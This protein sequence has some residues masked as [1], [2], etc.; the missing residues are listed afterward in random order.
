MYNIVIF[1]LANVAASQLLLEAKGS[2]SGSRI[3]TVQHCSSYLPLLKQHHPSQARTS[4][5]ITTSQ[6]K[7]LPS[8]Q[9]KKRS[10][11][12]LESIIESFSY[13]HRSHI[14]I[15]THL[16]FFSQQNKRRA[17]PCDS[18]W[19]KHILSKK[20]W[21]LPRLHLFVHLFFLLAWC[22]LA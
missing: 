7:V 3:S 19:P 5:H 4:R 13:H 18:V 1:D 11:S 20:R 14:H 22:V 17:S 10:H 21:L 9:P 16:I 12:S 2:L 15:H 6:S 8:V